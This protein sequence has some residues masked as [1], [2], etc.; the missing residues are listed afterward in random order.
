M[1]FSFSASV[2]SP[3]QRKENWDEVDTSSEKWRSQVLQRMKAS[4]MKVMLSKGLFMMSCMQRKHTRKQKML[5]VRGNQLSFLRVREPVYLHLQGLGSKN[6]CFTDC[7]GY[8]SL[9]AETKYMTPKMK[10]EMFI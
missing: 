2:P 9:T 7:L 6:N 4:E 1:T 10:E 3:R 5:Q 8:C